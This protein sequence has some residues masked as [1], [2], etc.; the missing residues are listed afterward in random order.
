MK[1]CEYL[2]K[3][4]SS[5]LMLSGRYT[6][7]Q[8]SCFQKFLSHQKWWRFRIFEVF[9]K[10]KNAFISKTVLDGA[11]STTFLTC[12]ISLQST[13]ANFQNIFVSPNIAA[14]F[15]FFAKIAKHKNAYILKTVLDRADC[16]DFGCHNSIRLETEHFLNTLALTFIS[17]SG[18]FVFAM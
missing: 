5:P 4:I 1:N 8:W 7:R 12:W 2:G 17:F 6:P 15:E 18:R 11:N 9:A 13:H 3:A 16:A 14:I 10:Q